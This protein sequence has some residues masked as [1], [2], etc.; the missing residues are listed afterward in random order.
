MFLTNRIPHT[1]WR[2]GGPEHSS[3]LSFTPI[4]RSARKKYEFTEV[5]IQ[6]PA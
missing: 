6:H 5:N 3:A 1:S 2:S 4:H